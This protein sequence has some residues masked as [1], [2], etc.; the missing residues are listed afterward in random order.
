MEF[1]YQEEEVVAIVVVLGIEKLRWRSFWTRHINMDLVSRFV[2]STKRHILDSNSIRTIVCQLYNVENDD[3]V[4]LYIQ[5]DN[6]WRYADTEEKEEEVCV[7]RI[8]VTWLQTRETS[9]DLIV[10][11]KVLSSWFVKIRTIRID[12]KFQYLSP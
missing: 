1:W 8:H 12:E 10:P 6:K 7:W 2:T 11:A 4:G 9:I 5:G 3:E